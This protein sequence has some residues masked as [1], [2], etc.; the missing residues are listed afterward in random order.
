MV[1]NERR[2]DRWEQKQTHLVLCWA[3]PKITRVIFGGCVTPP[4][5]QQ[6]SVLV[7]IRAFDLIIRAREASCG[8]SRSSGRTFR[9]YTALVLAVGCL[10]ACMKGLTGTRRAA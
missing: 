1:S 4:G 3:Q 10:G 5:D 7:V 9:V 2:E 8:V 6:V